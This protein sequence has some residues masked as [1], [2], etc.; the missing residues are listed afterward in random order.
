MFLITFLSFLKKPEFSPPQRI[1][2]RA[3]MEISSTLA[4]FHDAKRCHKV[5][6]EEKVSI[7]LSSGPTNH[8]S[9]RQERWVHRSNYG[10]G[11]MLVTNCSDW[12]FGPLPRKKPM[13][14]HEKSNQTCLRRPFVPKGKPTSVVELSCHSTQLSL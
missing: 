2:A 10:T 13:P 14:S 8:K 5:S 11:V 1:Q 4:S 6:G 9:T 3:Q 12:I 7:V